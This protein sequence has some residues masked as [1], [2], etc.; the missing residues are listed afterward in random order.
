MHSAER[1]STKF[2]DTSNKRQPCRCCEPRTHAANTAQCDKKC[3]PRSDAFE[4]DPLA[5][6]ADGLHKTLEACHILR[7]QGNEHTRGGRDVHERDDH[8]GR[9][10]RAWNIPAGVSNFTSHC[11]GSFDTTECECDSRPEEDVYQIRS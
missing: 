8:A 7:G 1:R 4:S 11:R 6:F 10:K 5:Y 9:Q 2:I 3:D